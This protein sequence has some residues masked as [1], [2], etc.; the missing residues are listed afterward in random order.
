[1]TAL[2]AFSNDSLWST[3]DAPALYL[4]NTTGAYDPVGFSPVGNAT[5]SSMPTGAQTS[6]F[7][8]YG[9]TLAWVNSDGDY[10]TLFYAS[11]STTSGTYNL[12]WNQ[13]NQFSS[14]AVPVTI[15]STAPSKRLKE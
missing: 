3:A 10:E 14:D 4:V 2:Y 6:G 1:M 7:G 9:H 15:K 13:P 5:N 12:L 11:N 8:W